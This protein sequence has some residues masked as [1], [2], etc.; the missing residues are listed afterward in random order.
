MTTTTRKSKRRGRGTLAI[1]GGLLLTSAA[2]RIAGGA[3]EAIALESAPDV[4]MEK[5]QT[6]QDAASQ[7]IH[8]AD[9]APVLEALRA[10]EM[11]LDKRETDIRKRLQALSVAEREI[12]KKM[13]ALEQAENDLRA[14]LALA[15]SAAEDD[16]TRLTD[17]YA[18]MK[19]KQAAALF[20]EMAPEFAAGFLGRMRPDSAAAIMAGLSPRAA[21]TISIVLAG[22]N[23]DVPKE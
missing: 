2:I 6:S 9:L 11:R 10:R 17:V 8:D 13:V 3:S 7:I 4:A 22:R 15:Q 19:P 5:E 14:T 23:A 18:N 16:L 12:D 21:Y 1:I 20:E